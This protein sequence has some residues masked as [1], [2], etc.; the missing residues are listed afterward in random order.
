M[1]HKSQVRLI[2]T[3]EGLSIL[4]TLNVFINDTFLQAI[5]R[6]TTINK[7]FGDIVYLG[8]DNINLTKELLI[9]NVMIDLEE[10]DISYSLSIIGEN[11][12]NEIENLQYNSKNSKIDELPFP[13][14]I[15][16][17]D[18]EDIEKQ[19]KG[20]EKYIEIN[21]QLEEINYE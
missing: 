11:I 13:S 17:F 16:T 1:G 3:K 21:K 15:R 20:L 6:N 5:L 7:T 4:K 10:R 2:T 18:E 19:L 9:K 12:E 14:I 8:W